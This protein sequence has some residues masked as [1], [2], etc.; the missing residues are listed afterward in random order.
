MPHLPCLPQRLAAALA[1][2]TLTCDDPLLAGTG[3]ALRQDL[4]ASS[5]TPGPSLRR[6]VQWNIIRPI[7]LL[8]ESVLPW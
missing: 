1:L 3:K 5:Y 4:A 7:S 6:S 2:P 8:N